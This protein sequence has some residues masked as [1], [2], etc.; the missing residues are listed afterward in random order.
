MFKTER[1]FRNQWQLTRPWLCY[2]N[3]KMWC[4]I[5]REHEDKILFYLKSKVMVD[6]ITVF[7]LETINKHEN[8]M[9]YDKNL[10][11][12]KSGLATVKSSRSPKWRL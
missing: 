10:A 2:D 5:C 9:F 11:T 4:H 3:G 6:G 1:K 12:M 8:S 7:K